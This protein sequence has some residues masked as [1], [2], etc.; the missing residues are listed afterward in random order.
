MCIRDRYNTL[1]LVPTLAKDPNGSSQGLHA[2]QVSVNLSFIMALD[3]DGNV[4]T[5]G[6]N[7]YGQLGNGTATG[8][9]STTYA[10]DPARVPDP[11]DTSKTFKATQISAGA[12]HAMAISQDGTLWTWGYNGWGQLGDGT[13]ANQSK[14]KQVGNPTNSSQPF[15][16]A[17]ISTGWVHSLAIDR[18]GTAWAWGYNYDGQLGD[19]TTNYRHTPTR[20]SPPAGQGN[21]GTGLATARI[22]AGYYHSMAI[23]HDGNTY[24]WGNNLYG[25]LGNGSATQCSTP[26]LVAFNSVLLITGVK[27]DKTAVDHLHQNSDGS[28]TLSTPVHSPGLADVI[29]DWSLGGVGQT[30]ARLAYTYEGVLPLTGGNGSMILL[31]AAGLLAAAGAAAAGRHRRET[32]ILQA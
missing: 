5:W 16:V 3:A 11:E 19:N 20:V 31:L 7:N 2:V 28:V 9:H 22:S 18:S 6:Y 15:Q 24:S 26:T 23:S 32:R 27:F 12:N 21:A 14:P 4:Y 8:E 13:T 17:Q 30:P 1:K 10:A 29:V 25:E